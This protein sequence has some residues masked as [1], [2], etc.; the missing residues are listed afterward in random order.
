MKQNSSAQL[1]GSTGHT[2]YT[3]FWLGSSITYTS[4]KQKSKAILGMNVMD[5]WNKRLQTYNPPNF[6]DANRY[7]AWRRCSKV[8]IHG[9]PQGSQQM[10]SSLPHCSW[11]TWLLGINLKCINKE[12]VGELF[13]KKVPAMWLKPVASLWSMRWENNIERG[14]ASR[15]AWAVEL[16]ALSRKLSYLVRPIDKKAS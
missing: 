14:L 7:S 15:P 10:R 13:K 9:L 1:P 3:D 6:S 16:E 5:Y 12:S 4:G 8:L 11:S 2:V